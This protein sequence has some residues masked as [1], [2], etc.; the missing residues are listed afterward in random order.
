MELR[1]LRSFVV[2]AEE[3]HFGRAAKRLGVVQPALSR[4]LQG[5]EEHVGFP[6]LRRSSRRV[7]MTPAGEAFLVHAQASLDRAEDALRAAR[8]GSADDYGRVRLGMASGAA[9]PGIGAALPRFRQRHPGVELSL[10]RVTEARLGTI[11]A[12]GRVDACVAW[13]DSVPAACRRVPVGQ[14]ALYA[15]VPETDPLAAEDTIALAQLA[16]RD[17]VVPSRATSPLVFERFTELC[18]QAGFA[19]RPAVDIDTIPQTLALVSGGGFVGVA[20]F[21]AGFSYPGV[22]LRPLAGMPLLTYEL[23]WLATATPA[24]RWVDALVEVVVEGPESSAAHAAVAS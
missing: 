22:A 18:R 2:L 11:L 19:L 7:A 8:V 14:V 13:D 17:L 9:Q 16:S 10:H 1:H 3:L 4:T 15:A 5:L 6:L 12:E 23:I 24:R 20:P 21:S